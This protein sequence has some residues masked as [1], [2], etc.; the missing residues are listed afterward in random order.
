M[1]SQGSNQ[2]I[3]N[4]VL[5]GASVLSGSLTANSQAYAGFGLN[6]LTTTQRD[7]LAVAPVAGNVIWNST[8]GQMQAYNGSA[9]ESADALSG[10]VIT[11]AVT[12]S[13]TTHAGIAF[14]N[15]TTTQ[16]DALVT[17][18]TGSAVWN[19]TTV[20]VNWY[21]GTNWTGF[22]VATGKFP[23]I[24]NTITLTGTDA[25]TLTLP[26]TS[27][28]IPGLG[29]A[30][31]W[32]ANGALS[33]G[34]GPAAT[35]NGTWITGGSATTTKPYFLLETTGA[36]STG[37]S[38]SG[39]GFGVN[40]A[41]GFTGNLIDAQ[42]NGT[43]VWKVSAAGVVSVGATFQFNSVASNK[44]DYNI[45]NANGW[46]IGGTD[47]TFTGT[48]ISTTAGGFFNIASRAYIGSS[49]NGLLSLYNASINN[50][51]RLCLG[52]ETAAF[53]GIGRDGAGTKFVG[54][55]G[56]SVSWIK[57]PSVAVGSLP[58]AA[59]AGEGARSFVT[60]ALTPV[61]G[62]TVSAGGTANVPV[63]SDG[64]NWIVG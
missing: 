39:T 55:D 46:T 19:T 48:T 3:V 41:T 44:L 63:Y 15:L 64:T 45:T 27:Q 47:L 59:T 35:F 7:A 42:L 16:R 22:K 60:D 24:N 12:F 52:G 9:W 4:A 18:A 28:T 1:R 11:G 56:T 43:S 25:T 33:S 49:A 5:L 62:S 31:V 13:G 2:N 30:N 53:P 61:P 57:V 54:G 10:G 32:T 26:T 37:W 58:A 50:F 23:V 8:T 20:A 34:A 6:S 36:T 14:N 17:P 29:Q 51:T 40:A 38:T 21:D